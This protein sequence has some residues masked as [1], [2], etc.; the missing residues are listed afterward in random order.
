MD[1]HV[2]MVPTPMMA[3]PIR[4]FARGLAVLEA[5]N[6]TGSATALEL[7]QRSG[8]PRPTVYR[9]LRTL[10]EAGYIGRGIGDERFHLLLKVRR[11]SGGFRDEQVLSEVAAPRLRELTERIGWP[12]DLS[13][14]EGLTMVIRDTTHGE[15]PQS[16]DRNMVGRMLPLLG[17]ATGL[18]YLAFAPP[19]ER[20]LL[21]ELLA[22]SEESHDVIAR[23]PVEANRLIAATQKRGYGARYGGSIWPHTGAIA[24]PISHAGR[25]LGCISAIWMARFVRLEDGI[26]RCLEPLRETRALIERDLS[27]HAAA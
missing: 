20:S 24:L 16:I 18:A 2:D 26:A 7:S 10:E 19:A 4:S 17:S 15:T 21:L 27:T 25:V 23:R 12:C 1:N 3:K 13:T 5:L 6:Q 11:L 14:L 22:R 8:V 9:L